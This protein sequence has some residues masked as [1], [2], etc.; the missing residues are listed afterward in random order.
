MTL[1]Q[2]LFDEFDSSFN[3]SVYRTN[4][5]TGTAGN[6]GFSFDDVLILTLRN[7]TDGTLCLAGAAVDALIVD[8]ISH[9][10]NA[11]PLLKK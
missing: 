1:R 3:R 5:R 4:V 6:T 8:Y 7:R 2:P 11:P 10:M 9:E